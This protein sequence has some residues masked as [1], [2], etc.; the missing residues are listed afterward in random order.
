MATQ[1]RLIGS[2]VPNA[3]VGA[4]VA[5]GKPLSP[6]E[7]DQNFINL[8]NSVDKII[9]EASSAVQEA[10]LFAAGYRI[11]IRVDLIAGYVPPTSPANIN[12][13]STIRMSSPYTI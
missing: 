13:T 4:T 9:G 7:V 12:P 6:A 11:V 10:A 3:T 1:L 5:K 2:T 8:Q